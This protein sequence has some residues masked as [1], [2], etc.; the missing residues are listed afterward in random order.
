[1]SEEQICR[2]LV[3][4]LRSCAAGGLVMGAS[5]NASARVPGTN[6]VAV[7]PTAVPYDFLRPEDVSVVDAS[8]LL[9]RGREPSIELPMHL[10]VYAGRREVG[11]IVH[12]HSAYATAL[13]C[14]L[15][16]IPVVAPEQAAAVGGE[17]PIVLYAPTGERAMGE[18]VIAGAGGRWAA[19]VRN[20]GPVCL[21]RQLAGALA[22]AFAVEESAR[23]YWLARV[24]GEPSRLAPEEVA[25]VALLASDRAHPS[26]PQP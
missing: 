26:R 2:E 19:V 13:G 5:G 11:A 24:L 6:L 7:S 10:A 25:R 1:M 3:E 22:C 9:V 18:A 23:V 14:L 15:D 17:I 4:A 16:E 20:H 12:T 8:G 21:G